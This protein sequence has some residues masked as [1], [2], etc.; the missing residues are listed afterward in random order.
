MACVRYWAG[1]R[2]VAGTHQQSVSATSLADLLDAVRAEHGERMARLIEMGVVMVDGE[3][4]ARGTDQ[5]LTDSSVVE[6][7]P[8]YAGG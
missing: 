8:P 3:K 5:P 4:V 7:L 6:V 1:A 2:D